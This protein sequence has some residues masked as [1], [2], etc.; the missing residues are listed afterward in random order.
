MKTTFYNQYEA[1]RKEAIDLITGKIGAAD[2]KLTYGE[3]ADVCSETAFETFDD[4]YPDRTCA[5]VADGTYETNQTWYILSLESKNQATV[6]DC[7]NEFGQREQFTL[8]D[9][10]FEAILDIADF[11]NS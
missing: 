8:S 2:G 10:S 7:I 5:F 1:L 6:I 3:Y 4:T 11:L 9:L